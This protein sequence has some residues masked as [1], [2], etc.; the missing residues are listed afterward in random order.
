M[1]DAQRAH[2]SFGD[3]TGG[4]LAPGDRG[5]VLFVHDA[6]PSL[7]LIRAFLASKPAACQDPD[8]AGAAGYLITFRD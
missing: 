2:P 6:M 5:A 8:D 7:R 4:R 1:Q 3:P